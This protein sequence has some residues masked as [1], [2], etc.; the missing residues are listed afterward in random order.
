MFD[1]T[2]EKEEPMR[3]QP[4]SILYGALLLDYG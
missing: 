3:W 4:G 2:K 1:P